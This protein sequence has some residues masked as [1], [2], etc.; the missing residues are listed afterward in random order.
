MH[1]AQTG[2]SNLTNVKVS[3]VPA[4]RNIAELRSFLGLVNY[5]GKFLQEL[6]TTLSPLYVLL[7]KKKKGR[8]RTK[9]SRHS[10]SC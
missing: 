2:L 10:R 4:A 1:V 7:Q 6:A 5:Y 8:A 9:H 3:R